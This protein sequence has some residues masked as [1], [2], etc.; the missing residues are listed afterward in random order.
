MPSEMDVRCC[1]GTG[2]PAD[3]VAFEDS[4]E[5]NATIVDWFPASSKGIVVEFSV[6]SYTRIG[7]CSPVQAS[8]SYGT[9]VDWNSM[10][11][12]EIP[13]PGLE[14]MASLYTNT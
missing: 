5:R 14:L 6:W 7:V 3:V 11:P 1:D 12:D 10:E 13:S 8:Y 4:E 9:P 2:A